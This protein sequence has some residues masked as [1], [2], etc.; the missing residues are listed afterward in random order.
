MEALVIISSSYTVKQ[1][2]DRVVM[3]LEGLGMSIYARIN[4]Q[5]ESKWC[6]IRFPPMECL[7]FDDPH[8]SIPVV[9][10]NPVLGL[11]FPMKIIVWEEDGCQIAFRDPE[12]LLQLYDPGA[13]SLHWPDLRTDISDA[14]RE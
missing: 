4:R 10:Q 9:L 14:L 7:L 8:L 1:T 2:M 5:V 6:G 13:D 3:L 12:A 11:C